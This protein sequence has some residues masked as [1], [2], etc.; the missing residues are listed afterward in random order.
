MTVKS[1]YQCGPG[2]G[3]R[4]QRAYEMR[5]A[6]S[7][8]AEVAHALQPP[9]STSE[10]ESANPESAVTNLAKKY[11]RVQNLP[12]PISIPSRKVILIDDG[13]PVPSLSGVIRTT[14]RC[15]YELRS[16]GENWTDVAAKTGYSFPS[17]AIAGAKRHALREGL[18]WP[19]KVESL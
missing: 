5:A 7:T 2:Y 1:T 18:S 6:G 12:W 17:H 15:A 4:G 14:Q 9:S 16:Q 13:V 3:T 11:A 8:W 19:I 10:S